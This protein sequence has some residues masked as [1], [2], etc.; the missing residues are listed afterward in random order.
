MGANAT[1]K[2][3]T[4]VNGEVLEAA[5]LNITN[6]GIPVFAT[7]T[8]RDAAFG[9]A[10]EKTL[11]QGQMA[12]IEATNTTQFYD[13]SA[14]ASVGGAAGLTLITAQTIGTAVSSV[15]VSDVFSATYENYLVTLNGGV[16]SALSGLNMTLGSTTT[17][18][19]WGL[20]IVTYAG[21]S[22]PVGNANVASWYSG[23]TTTSASFIDVVIQSPQLATRSVFAGVL[24]AVRTNGYA[25][26]IGGFLDNAT[27]YTGF[28]ITP[29][30][31]TLTG[32]TIRV[33]GYQNS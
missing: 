33:Y 9:G 27:Q 20:A 22:L 30:S 25:G 21:A 14:W 10:G 3:P 4:Y 8:T 32:G 11:A 17:G 16:G 29:T 24:S 19:Y 28:T 31:A 18:Y 7:T 12:F 15:V 1:I 6:S 5:D 13:G 2:V 23:E 26:G